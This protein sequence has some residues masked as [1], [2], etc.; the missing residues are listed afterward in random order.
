MNDLIRILSS[1]PTF[2]FLVDSLGALVTALFLLLIRQFFPVYFGIPENMLAGL[3]IM[4]C[5]FSV[6]SFSCFLFVKKKQSFFLKTIATAN[7]LYC[8]LTVVLVY[9]YFSPLTYRGIAYF[10]IEITI[11]LALVYLEWNVA[12]L[13]G[14]NQVFTGCYRQLNNA[15]P[16]R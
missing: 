16:R 15:R 8:V 13:T 6:F 11:I 9:Y 1:N 7:F 12:T 2:V 10:C 14:K 3:I 5:L 4:A